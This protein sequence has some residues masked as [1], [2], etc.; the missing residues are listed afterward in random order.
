M[1]NYGCWIMNT[2]R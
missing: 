1:M 2:C